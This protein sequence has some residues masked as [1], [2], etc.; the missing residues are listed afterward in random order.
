VAVNTIR[1]EVSGATY[2]SNEMQDKL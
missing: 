2:G 1:Q